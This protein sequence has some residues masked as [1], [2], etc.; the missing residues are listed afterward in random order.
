MHGTTRLAD[1]SFS[2]MRLTPH[3]H[4]CRCL[5][6]P[7]GRSTNAWNSAQGAALAFES[8]YIFALLMAHHPTPSELPSLLAAY[9]AARIPRAAA[10]RARS[11]HM[12]DICQLRDGPDQRE[13]DRVLREDAPSP[14]FPNPWADPEW[15][16]FMWNFDAATEEARIWQDTLDRS[17]VGATSAKFER[18]L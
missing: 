4:I 17:G 11:K 14:G 2:V 13:R 9:S 16:R 1:F 5:S 10:I 8:A 18:S 7:R 12:H 15:A 3:C 6:R